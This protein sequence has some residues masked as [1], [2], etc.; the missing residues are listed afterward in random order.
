MWIRGFKNHNIKLMVTKGIIEREHFFPFIIANDI[1][2]APKPT[3]IQKTFKAGKIEDKVIALQQL[4]K[5]INQDE[6]Y[7]PLM[8]SVLQYLNN[9]KLD[10][11]FFK[12]STHYSEFL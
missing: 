1:E 5:L 2:S 8:M 4:I 7:P 11:K 6:T 12:Q 9:D 3:E 10:I